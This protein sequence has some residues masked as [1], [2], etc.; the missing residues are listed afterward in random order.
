[1]ES[2]APDGL[3]CVCI[4]SVNI[5][6]LRGRPTSAPGERNDRVRTKMGWFRLDTLDPS[7]DDFC[8]MGDENLETS[9]LH[10]P[11]FLV[12]CFL[13]LLRNSGDGGGAE[14]RGGIVTGS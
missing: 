14:A 8:E 11:P 12:V 3:I 4:T 10:L 5:K 2:S 1:M 9:G 7:A 13:V 6:A